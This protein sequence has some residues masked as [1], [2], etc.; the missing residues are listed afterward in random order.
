MPLTLGMTGMDPATETALKAAFNDANSRLGNAWRL[1]AESE[2]GHVMVD[3]DSMY[4]PMSW[5]RLHAAGKKVIGLT[6]AQR[7]QTDYRLGRPFDSESFTFLLRDVAAENGVVPAGTV[8]PDV[9]TPAAVAAPGSAPASA[10]PGVD[11]PEP[12]PTAQAPEPD[13]A[14]TPEPQP[15]AAEAALPPGPVAPPPA[16]ALLRTPS[17]ATPASTERTLGD[18]LEPGALD[19]RVRYRAADGATLLIDPTTRKYY[20]PSTLKSLAKDVGGVVR[21]GDFEDIDDAAWA[22]ESRAAGDA[23]PLQRLQWLGALVAG[24]GNLLPGY[25]PQGHYRL[26]KWPQTEREYPRH[27][28]IATAMMKTPATVAGIAEASGM[29]VADV[30]DFVNASLATGFADLVTDT[31][32][33]PVEAPKPTGLF[34]RLRGR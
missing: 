17:Q 21:R 3:M 10:E 14:A 26:N 7:S 20:G 24:K 6:T 23:Q 32:A 29:P 16:P 11:A 33:E 8:A 34:G 9:A 2:A 25:D 15:A 30:A 27:F 4:G 19:R 22:S 1:V 5:L 31:P 18:W 12:S 13:P 28:R